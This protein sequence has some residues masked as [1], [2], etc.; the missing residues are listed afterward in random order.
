MYQ[1]HVDK[2]TYDVF[3]HTHTY[4]FVSTWIEKSRVEV[5]LFIKKK[6]VSIIDW[7]LN[8]GNP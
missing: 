3:T 5:E 1:S 7:V 4:L 8:R 6:I 2:V